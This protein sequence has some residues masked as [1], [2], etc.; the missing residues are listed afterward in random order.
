VIHGL[1]NVIFAHT[2]HPQQAEK[3]VEFLGSKQAAELEADTGTVIPAFNGTQQAWV[4]AYPQYDVQSYLDELNYAVPYPI[5]RNTAAWNT[6]ESNLLPEAWDLSKPVPAVAAQLA[7]Q[8]NQALA[9]E[10]S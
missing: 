2:R 9:K 1:A 10:N 4:N 6:F 5:S 3:F 8:M 7:S